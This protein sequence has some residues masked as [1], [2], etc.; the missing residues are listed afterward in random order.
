MLRSIMINEKVGV[1]G[2]AIPSKELARREKIKKQTYFLKIYINNELLATTPKVAISWPDFEV[3]FKELLNVF[4]FT[5]PYSISIEICQ[6]GFFSTVLDRIEISIPGEHANSLTSASTIYRTVEYQKKNIKN[7]PK[8]DQ[9][10]KANVPKNPPKGEKDASNSNPVDDHPSDL[11]IPA[12]AGE[13]PSNETNKEKKEEENHSDI[14]DDETLDLENKIVEVVE[15]GRLNLEVGWI[16]C[17]P[18]LPPLNSGGFG[19]FR[20]KK[21]EKHGYQALSQTDDDDEVL[22]DVNDP[23]SNDQVEKVREIRNNEL[24]S[25][26]TNDMKVPLFDVKSMRHEILKLSLMDYTSTIKKL[27]T[28]ML[29]VDVAQSEEHRKVL[30]AHYNEISN[31][32]RENHTYSGGDVDMNNITKIESFP[33]SIE[34]SKRISETKQTFLKKQAEIK[35]KKHTGMADIASLAATIDEFRFGDE[36]NNIIQKLLK[37]FEP[38]RKLKLPVTKPKKEDAREHSECVVSVQAIKGLNV[39]AREKDTSRPQAL[40]FIAEG[41]NDMIDPPILSND[42]ELHNATENALIHSEKYDFPSS[43]LQMTIVDP[44]RRRKLEQETNDAK[45]KKEE[46]WISTVAGETFDGVD[47]EWNQNMQLKYSNY[48][49]IKFTNQQLIECQA[50]LFLTLFD[51][52]G[53]VEQLGQLKQSKFDERESKLGDKGTYEVQID[54]KFLGNIKIPLSS[55]FLN[56]KI[57]SMFRVNRPIF[58]S[59]YISSKQSIFMEVNDF[60]INFVDPYLPTYLMLSISIEPNFELPDNNNTD[61]Y[62]GAEPAQFLLAGKAFLEAIFKDKE[63]KGRNIRLWGSDMKGQSVFIPRYITPQEPPADFFTVDAFVDGNVIESKAPEGP[64]KIQ[65]DYELYQ[66]CARYVA[67]IPVK[68]ESSFFR[69]MPDIFMSSQEFLDMRAGDYEE[70][71]ILLCNYFLFIDKKHNLDHVETMVIM[72]RGV[73]EGKTYYVLRRD[74]KADSNE[75]WNPVTGEVY[76]FHHRVLT[77]KFLCFKFNTGVTVE[78]GSRFLSGSHGLYLSPE[79]CGL[80]RHQRQRLHQHTER[81]ER[82]KYKLGHSEQE[83]FQ[84]FSEVRDSDEANSRWRSSS[85]EERSK[86]S[87]VRSYT[88]SPI[89]S[90]SSVWRRKSKPTLLTESKTIGFLK[91][92]R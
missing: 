18:R 27:S 76:V 2:R 14:P 17:G 47:P 87:N 89:L 21:Q 65:I 72:G 28:S 26:L 45:R 58:M 6:G 7:M 90:T 24:R 67:L 66:K 77:T 69:D 60:D 38:R 5:K 19:I 39:P 83:I 49:E 48:E 53:S 70:H 79:V 43:F 1:N 8:K 16:G 31:L 57:D 64:G 85:Q 32:M 54:S 56:P 78:S 50:N 9:K 3:D 11:V 44:D 73:P 59:G 20:L 68:N 37:I 74:T 84:T 35:S 42:K 22:I 34:A 86:Q 40:A 36:E 71:A 61:Y 81:Q 62:P 25:L 82:R 13:K 51:K 30:E 63:N 29:E 46:S 88:K 91:G 23:R 4:I 12:H 10:S 92:R 52:F 15:S 55:L 41:G 75:I 80:S 33:Y